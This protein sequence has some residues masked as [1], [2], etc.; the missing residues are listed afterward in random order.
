MHVHL[1][2]LSCAPVILGVNAH[3]VPYEHERARDLDLDV[4]R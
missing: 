3:V 1:A 4:T 2:R